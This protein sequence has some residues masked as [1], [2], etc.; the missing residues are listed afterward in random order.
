MAVRPGKVSVLIGDCRRWLKRLPE[1][2]VQTVVTSPPYWGLRDY[3][4]PKLTWGGDSRCA[5]SWQARRWYT[6]QSAAG[7]N[8]SAEAFSTP[9]P[10][11]AARLKA[12]RWREDS[13]CGQCGAWRGQ[14]GLEPTPQLYVEHLVQVFRRVR[15]VLR[16][17]G[18]LWVVVGDS[19]CNVRTHRNGGAPTNT[20]HRGGKRDGTED[21]VRP[22]RLGNYGLTEKNLVGVP[23]RLAFALQADG[24]IL[25]QDIIWAKAISGRG[26]EQWA[27]S[28]MPESV[29]DRC[30]R[31]H[32]HVFLLTKQPTYFYDV[33]AVA[34]PAKFAGDVKRYDGQQKNATL[35]GD[36]GTADD[37]YRTRFGRTGGAL[38]IAATRNLRDVWT[39]SPRPWKGAHTA[40]FPEALVERC[41]RAGTSR[42]GACARCGAPWVRITRRK[43]KPMRE[44]L[45]SPYAV[46]KDGRGWGPSCACA[47]RGGGAQRQPC[48]VL[49]PFSG[50]GT[51]SKVAARLGR[52]SIA[53]ELVHS[54][55]IA[56]RLD[57]LDFTV[58]DRR[59]LRRA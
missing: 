24:W 52:D 58:K 55:D 50:T 38:K 56:R 35:P 31:A 51:T 9:G 41:V 6:I 21:H 19:Y 18:T 11:N 43:T 10:D 26:S 23:W 8:G 34:E 37:F 29:L 12:A 30:T 46:V 25:R 28:A 59:D 53:V 48:V 57:G 4:G 54:A 33:R 7:R 2:S 15:R 5:H 17:D 1:K 20:V 44:A 45:R 3:G 40:T 13:T 39:I 14:L 47:W 16:D 22:N 49:D 32:E 27:G 42:K 36:R